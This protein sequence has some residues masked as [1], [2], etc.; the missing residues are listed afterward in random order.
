M[1]LP[2]VNGP[3]AAHRGGPASIV[4]WTG[5]GVTQRGHATASI[6]AIEPSNL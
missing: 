4:G 5:T 6:H 3:I 2:S 1:A